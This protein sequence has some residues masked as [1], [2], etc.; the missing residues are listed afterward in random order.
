MYT[1]KDWSIFLSFLSAIF[2]VNVSVLYSQ[3]LDFKKEE[4]YFTNAEI[5]NVYSKHD[6]QVLKL[7]NSEITFFTS[8][9]KKENYHLFDRVNITLVTSDIE[10][11]DY[12][13]GFYAKSFNLYLQEHQEESLKEKLSLSIKTQHKDEKISRLFDALFF[14]VPLSQQL[15]DICATYGIS[16]LIAISGFHLGVISFVVFWI[17]YY[18]YTLVHGKYFPY[19]NKKFDILMMTSLLLLSYL[20]FTQMVPSLL[21][22]FVMFILGIYFL[23]FNF[24]LISFQTLLITVLFIIAF[25]PEYLF[26]LSLWFSVIAVLYIFL[27]LK[28]FDSLSKVGQFIFFNFWIYLV[29]NPVS[30]YFFGDTALIQFLSPIV[31]VG[32]TLFYPLEILFHLIGFGGVLDGLIQWAISVKTNS[33]EVFTPMWFFYGYVLLS[34]LSIVSKKAFVLLNIMFVVFNIYIYTSQT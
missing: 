12:T 19:R 31:T 32:F 3:Y 25:F 5:S 13:K 24:K 16:H 2:I 29:M 6:Y 14:A 30:H 18:P 20:I 11:F 15:R 33:Y 10:F 17:L 34:F 7:K 26:L 23:R 8:V 4:L 9:S 27:F 1:K 28:Y 21:R 22:A